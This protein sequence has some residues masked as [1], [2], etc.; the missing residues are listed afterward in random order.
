MMIR[1]YSTVLWEFILLNR[2][3]LRGSWMF[4]FEFVAHSVDISCVIPQVC[5][6]VAVPVFWVLLT[7]QFDL[8]AGDF[9]ISGFFFYPCW[10]LIG[11]YSREKENIFLYAGFYVF[12]HLLYPLELYLLFGP[13]S[14][15]CG[16]FFWQSLRYKPL[17]SPVLRVFFVLSSS[18]QTRMEGDR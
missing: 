7:V 14:R 4:C 2:L 18:N 1:Q 17:R 11:T 13:L 10:Y 9:F 15:I 6:I 16:N 8:D 5:V 12:S 3:W